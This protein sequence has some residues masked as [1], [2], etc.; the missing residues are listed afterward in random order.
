MASE[1]EPPFVSVD[2]HQGE[3]VDAPA[4]SGAVTLEVTGH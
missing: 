2:D 3:A 4:L 1:V